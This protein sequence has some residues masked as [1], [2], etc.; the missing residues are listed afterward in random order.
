L[1]DTCP[2][3]LGQIYYAK[4][5]FQPNSFMGNHR[6]ASS[7]EYFNCSNAISGTASNFFGFQNSLS[8]NGYAGIIVRTIGST[9]ANY[10]EYI[11]CPLLKPLMVGNKYCVEM[12]VCLAEYSKISTTRLGFVFSNDSIN[13]DA[14][15][16]YWFKPLSFLAPQVENDSTAFITDTLNWVLISGSFIAN[17][18]E[19]FLTIG[20]FFDD[21]RTPFQGTGFGSSLES[22][23]YYYI[24]DVSVTCCDSSGICEEPVITN[25][26][27]FIPNAFS[28]N[29]D[30][31]NDR[32]RVLGNANKIEFKVFDRWGE[33]VYS[34]TG[35]EM[36]A[37]TGWD[38]TYKGKQ[39]DNAVFVYFAKVTLP[40]G[41]E[42]E[43]KGNVSLIK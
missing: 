32:L 1:V 25:N 14:F 9:T 7:S 5:W 35:G 40:D 8:G 31:H 18:G 37:G 36:S 13:A 22:V 39:L 29:N 41:K 42:V 16:P 2:N 28:P 11:E 15:S 12:Y 19:R 43:M 10:R 6:I 21:N 30:G 34:Y 27:L 33:M 23:A 4:P 17:G 20:N 3:N 26:E 38:G 24:D